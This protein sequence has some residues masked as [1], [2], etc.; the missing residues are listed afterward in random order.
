M[1]GEAIAE[2]LGAG[3]TVG[4]GQV[5]VGTFGMSREELQN[6]RVAVDVIGRFLG[7]IQ[8]QPLID[9]ENPNSSIATRYNCGS[10]NSITRYGR[11]VEFYR[12]KFDADGTP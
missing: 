5:T 12:G 6:P 4:I 9:P 2:R 7:E 11:R 1:P 3:Q 8:Q 10:C